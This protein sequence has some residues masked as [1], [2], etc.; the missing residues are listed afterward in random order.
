[1]SHVRTEAKRL[2]AKHS[3]F[4]VHKRNDRGQWRLVSIPRPRRNPSEASED[5]VA[6]YEE[7]HRYKPTEIGEF[8]ADF[9]IPKTV[10]RVGP[11]KYTTYR[12]AKVDPATL[13]KPR[14]PVN[15]I[16]EHDAGVEVYLQVEADEQF[17][18]VKVYVP[19]KFRNVDSLVCLGQNLGY[20]FKYDGEV[21]EA[22]GVDPL[23]EL[24]CVPSGECLLV[25]QDK[26]EVIA[27]IWG[28]GLGV[29][30]RGIDG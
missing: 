10:L 5:A 26:R 6:K 21:I 7:F 17:D 19:E 23:P 9:V 27:M 13:K 20:A 22:E 11:A 28:G 8:H 25:I 24:Y 3:D 30:A 29:F 12:S 16:H 14:A 2:G 15:Y 18:G 4:D 1:M